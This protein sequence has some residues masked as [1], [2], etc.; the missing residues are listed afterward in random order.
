MCEVLLRI[1]RPEDDVCVQR[2]MR[3]SVMIKEI[4]IEYL[5]GMCYKT[6]WRIAG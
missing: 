3:A 2:N 1:D 6:K 4:T 5:K